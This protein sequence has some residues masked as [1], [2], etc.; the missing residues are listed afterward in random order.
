MVEAPRP[1]PTPTAPPG[2]GRPMTEE[3]VRIA[4][5]KKRP[6]LALVP[7]APPSRQEELEKLN[8]VLASSV[9]EPDETAEKMQKATE[10][11]KAC[12]LQVMNTALDEAEDLATK[13]GSDLFV[14]AVKVFYWPE[15][16]H[17]AIF[18]R[19]ST[20]P[21][22]GDGVNVK[23]DFRANDE[24][25]NHKHSLA[26]K[27]NNGHKVIR[28]VT[29]KRGYHEYYCKALEYE[30]GMVIK[31]YFVVD[32]KEDA[33]VM[34]PRYYRIQGDTVVTITEREYNIWLNRRAAR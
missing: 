13:Q 7:A 17:R 24:P 28:S 6:M 12:L 30:D 32:G 8:G 19:S 22:L 25:V 21:W 9:D 18:F 1:E 33:A 29:H 2:L 27:Q 10:H 15:L 11:Q 4:K 20:A 34:A 3:E 14:N 5:L 26:Y 23:H 31:G 16:N